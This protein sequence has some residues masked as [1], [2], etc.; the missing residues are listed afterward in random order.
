MS[1]SNKQVDEIELSAILNEY[2]YCDEQKSTYRNKS[3]YDIINMAPE[4]SKIHKKF[5]NYFIFP[6]TWFIIAL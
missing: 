2:V 1:I 6:N 5:Y 4:S 3:L